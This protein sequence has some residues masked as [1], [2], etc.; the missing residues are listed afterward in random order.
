MN[1][2]TRIDQYWSKRADEFGDARYLDLH[3]KNR[4]DW[5]RVIQSYLPD[6]KTVHALDLGTGAGFF[7]FLLYDLG[8]KVTGIDYSQAMIDN[9]L[10]IQEKLGYKDVSFHQMD[11]QSLKFKDNSFNF[12]F[13]RNVTWTLPDPEKAY[14]EMYRVLAPGGCLLNFDANYGV[15]FEQQDAQGLTQ[16]QAEEHIG[17]YPFPA[18]SLEMLRERNDIATQ[19]SVCNK[20]RPIWDVEV[21]T[22]LGVEQITMDLAAQRH[23]EIQQTPLSQQ[24]KKESQPA[25][26]FMIMAKK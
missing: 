16:Q 12:I 3:S 26:L 15:A 11:A 1:M 2:Q 18:R 13:T 14:A 7:S 10:K 8:C 25:P 24:E 23:F 20:K 9:A 17:K 21:L 19:L 5:T 22:G 4:E 6:C